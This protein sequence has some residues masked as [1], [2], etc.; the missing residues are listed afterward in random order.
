MVRT[1]FAPSP[2]GLMHVGNLRTAV[3]AFALAKHNNGR[4][5]LRIEDTDQKRYDPNGIDDIKNI[6]TAF[7]LK[8]DEFYIQS[9]RK[10][11]GV[12]QQVA[13]KLVADHHAF[14]CQCPARNAKK[15]GFSQVLRDP[16]R[17]KNLASG[18]I[19]LKVPDDQKISYRDFVLA[20]DVVWNTNTVYDATL[21]KS[22]GF[23]TYHLA[24]MTDDVQMNI[25]HILR[26]HDWM[27]STPIHLLVLDFIGGT[28]PEIGHLTDIQSPKGGKLSKRRDSVFCETYLQEGYLPGAL[29]N[30][31]ILLGWAPKDNRELFTLE[32]FVAAFDPSG[33]QK[34]NPL[35]T[36]NKLNWLNGH[37]IRKKMDT[38]LI[39]LVK[40][41]V[42]EDA[43]DEKLLQIIPLV[44]DRLVKLSDFSALT[45]FFFTP[46][47]YTRDLWT[48]PAGSGKHLELGLGLLTSSAWNKQEIE[49][50]LM[51]LI[52]QKGWKVGDFFM[53]L[54]IAICGSRHTPPLT[55]TMLVLGK[56]ET[57]RRINNAMEH[58]SL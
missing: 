44:K 53:S 11:A 8:W 34:A 26:G 56:E 41:Y 10:N 14:Y 25:S 52:N 5:V 55:E 22:D 43:L 48:D 35:F 42:K 13:E 31:V 49:S 36:E 58:L 24:A 6:L 16:C 17:N 30:F 12:Y 20:K 32:E 19:K 3:Y 1:R 23:P 7:G 28:R 54:R 9:E 15:E 18:A 40:Q 50:N 4:F 27:P 51:T 2:T 57:L 46:P 38:E 45:G 47:A 21:L 39:H 29:L 37:Y 33:F